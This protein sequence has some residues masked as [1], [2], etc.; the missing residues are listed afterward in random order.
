[1]T[2]KKTRE[3]VNNAS[4]EELTARL[5]SY[6]IDFEEQ[7][8][9]WMFGHQYYDFTDLLNEYP[10]SFGEGDSF[11]FIGQ[12]VIYYQCSNIELKVNQEYKLFGLGVA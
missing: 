7:A 2:I 11:E 5:Q 8:G 10:F 12:R 9:D 4:L 6:G 1:M 3:F